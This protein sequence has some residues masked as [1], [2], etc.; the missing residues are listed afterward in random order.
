MFCDTSHPP[1]VIKI[2]SLEFHSGILYL[3]GSF[4]K[5]H[6]K[7]KQMETVQQL[8]YKVKDIALA[9]WGRKEIELA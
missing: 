5:Y 1:F 7:D 4:S 9:D 6:K 2:S 8:K 3:C